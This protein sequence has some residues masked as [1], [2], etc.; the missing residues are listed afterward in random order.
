MDDTLD[1][2]AVGRFGA[3]ADG[4]DDCRAQ[5]GLQC[6]PRMRP[7]FELSL[8]TLACEQDCQLVDVAREARAK[9]AIG[10][11]PLRGIGEPWGQVPPEAFGRT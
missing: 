7:E 10:S 11:E 8:P 9:A 1:V 2:A 5:T 6:E 4:L 3:H